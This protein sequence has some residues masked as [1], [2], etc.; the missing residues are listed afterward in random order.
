MEFDYKKL[1][2]EA[3]EKLPKKTEFKKRFEIPQVIS[4]IQGNKTLIKNFRDIVSALRREKEYLAKY[5]FKELAVPGSFQGDTLIFQSK[6]SKEIL[7]K[8]IEEYAK[9]FVFCK[10]CGEPDTKLIKE[11]RF[12]FIK[13]EACGAK[14]P[15]RVV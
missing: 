15:A 9:E 3:M 10:V 11:D 12:L 8:K 5:L 1:L 14:T 6:F 13:C 7:Q 2:E 4:E